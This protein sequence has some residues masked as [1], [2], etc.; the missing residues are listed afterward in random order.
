MNASSPIRR[1]IATWYALAAVAV[2]LAAML[3]LRGLVRAS[4]EH[5]FSESLDTS[6]QLVRGFFRSELRE[7]RTTAATVYHI[8]GE[9][10]FADRRISFVKPDG[11]VAE[12]A[13][14]RANEAPPLKPPVRDTVAPL[15]PDLAPGWMVRVQH[16]QSVVEAFERRLDVW[17]YAGIP[18]LIALSALVGWMLAGRTLAPVVAMAEASERINASQPST[19]LPIADSGDELGRLGTRFNAV[20][21]RLDGALAQQRRFLAAAAHELRTPIAR[22]SATMEL[23]HAEPDAAARATLMTQAESEV[24]RLGR[25][26]DELMQL[27]RADAEANEVRL[28]DGF[29]DD[30]VSDV[31]AASSAMATQRGVTLEVAA[32]EEAPARLDARLVD[33]LVGILL[34]NALRYTPS[35]GRVTVRVERVQGAARL[36]V[37]DTGIGIPEGERGRI[38]ERFYRGADARQFE[39][40]GSGLGLAIAKWICE[41]HSATISALNAHNGTGTVF[42]VLFPVL[43]ESAIARDAL[44]QP[45]VG[46]PSG[47]RA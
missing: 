4:I 41:Q 47:A 13:P 24:V 19:R 2:L 33:R 37:E 26:V 10:V 8:G 14:G 1:R 32:L 3:T 25:L 12:V 36:R 15:D 21:D 16:S 46:V 35:G 43:R 31:V 40:S 11:S 38:F 17:Y 39:P 9:T 5:E 45:V 27:A 7:F 6:V 30:V 23:A 28:A 42:E 18:A 44:A 22:L 34:E 29:V 20:L